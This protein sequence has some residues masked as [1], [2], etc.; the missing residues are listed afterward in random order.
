MDRLTGKVAVIAGGTGPIGLATALHFLAQGAKV[1]LVD[2]VQP[3]RGRALRR[4]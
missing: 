3:A 1:V 2:Q 4:Q